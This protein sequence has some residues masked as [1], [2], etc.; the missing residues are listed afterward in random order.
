LVDELFLDTSYLLPIFGVQ[1]EYRN[2]E[3]VFSKLHER[4]SLKYNPVSLIEAK[5]IILK[6]SKKVLDQRDVL[7]QAY[8]KGLLSLEK[9]PRLQ[10]SVLTSEAIEEL[11]DNLLTEQGVTDYFDRQIYSTASILHSILLTEDEPLHE[12]FN[13]S[14]TKLPKPRKIMKWQNL[15][16]EKK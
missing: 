16:T 7:L 15:L 3:S 5:W 10:G 2:F 8:R 14:G 11:S 12:L 1:L 13:K 6:H 4:Y 9:D